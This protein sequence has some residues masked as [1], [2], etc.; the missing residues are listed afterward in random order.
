MSILDEKAFY[1]IP[2]TTAWPTWGWPT[3]RTLV[4]DSSTMFTFIMGRWCSHDHAGIDYDHGHDDGDH[5]WW[6]S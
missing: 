6:W 2:G 3:L 5:D 4:K 1:I